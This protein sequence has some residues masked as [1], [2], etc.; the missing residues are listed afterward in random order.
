MSASKSAEI[1]S[2]TYPSVMIS[3]VLLSFVAL[4]VGFYLLYRY[5]RKRAQGF[6]QKPVTLTDE[7][8]AQQVRSAVTTD[9][10]LFGRLF[11]GPAKDGHVWVLL[12]EFN[13]HLLWVCLQNARLGFW[14]LN[15]E[16]APQWRII[17]L[18]VNS[19]NQYLRKQEPTK[20]K[21]A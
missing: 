7:W 2:A 17:Q 15:A 8:L 21:S 3:I 20:K 14:T 6:S 19:L 4:L 11:A 12:K 9:N 5:H 10:P 1:G 16:G 13:H 18:H